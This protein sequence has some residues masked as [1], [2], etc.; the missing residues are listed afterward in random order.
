MRFCRTFE[1]LFIICVKILIKLK[2]LNYEVLNYDNNKP[3]TT[4]IFKKIGIIL[5]TLD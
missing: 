2:K 5:D 4:M 3:F 1:I